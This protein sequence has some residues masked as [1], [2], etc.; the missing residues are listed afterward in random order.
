[1]YQKRP[2]IKMNGTGNDFVIFDAR[3]QKL[4]LDAARIQDVADRKNRVTGGCDQVIIIERSRK[5]DCSMRIFNADGGE[6]ESCGNASRCVGWLLMEEAG[7]EAVTIDTLGGFLSVS[8]AG[9]RMVRVNMG[10]PHLGW[11]EIPLA[12]KADTLHLPVESGSLKDP[13]G[14]SMGNPHAVFFVPDV[15][16]IDLQTHGPVL[17]HHPLFPERANIGVAQ[18]LG[19]DRIRLRVFER[20]VGETQACGTGACAAL[21][22]ANRR[23]LTERKA[24]IQ[25][26]G[27]ELLI[28][29]KKNGHVIM[30]GEVSEARE[31]VC[32]I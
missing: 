4:K 3:E 10:V 17:E 22:A 25:V 23:G 1:M 32:E 26:N 7:K 6:V 31:G 14:V 11:D 28:E 12:H 29:W 30:T 15:E 24:S 16:R 2:F 20:G 27:G 18:V 21:V 13:V 8:R 19:K 9:K 5:A